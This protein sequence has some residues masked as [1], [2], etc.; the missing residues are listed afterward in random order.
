ML[1]HKCCLSIWSFRTYSYKHTFIYEVLCLVNPYLGSI[2]SLKYDSQITRNLKIA[3]KIPF[4][5]PILDTKTRICH[6]TLITHSLIQW[7]P[8]KDSG[9]NFIIHECARKDY[10]E[11]QNLQCEVHR[12]KGA[13]AMDSIFVH[14][15][16]LSREFDQDLT[17]NLLS[18]FALFKH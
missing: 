13:L 12:N 6:C 7:I 9:D 17:V 14:I 15:L 3:K 16:P 11:K 18:S 1:H 8:K 4:I 5:K 10:M 2:V